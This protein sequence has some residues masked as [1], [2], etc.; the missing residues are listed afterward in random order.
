MA[1]LRCAWRGEHVERHGE[2]AVAQGPRGKWLLVTDVGFGQTLAVITDHDH[3]QPI[4]QW[5]TGFKNASLH[6]VTRIGELRPHPPCGPGITDG[7]YIGLHRHPLSVG[8]GHDGGQ[9]KSL[10]GI[11]QHVCRPVEVGIV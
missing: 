5:P 9:V 1:E 10:R 11:L 8:Q 3:I 7:Q 2:D 6:R 4:E